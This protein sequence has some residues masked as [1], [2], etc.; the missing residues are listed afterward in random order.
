MEFEPIVDFHKCVRS[1]SLPSLHVT[2][3]EG[4]SR[5]STSA[6][7]EDPDVS[8]SS[9]YLGPEDD[10]PVPL[11][12]DAPYL[13][14]TPSFSR[15][16]PNA[17][18][19]PSISGLRMMDPGALTLGGPRWLVQ[20]ASRKLSISGLRRMDPSLTLTGPRCLVQPGHLPRHSI[21]GQRM[22]L[23]SFTLGGNP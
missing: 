10:P 22:T 5:A 16:C 1:S 6:G 15:S 12:A 2:P 23:Q 9:I 13:C 3:F 8:M 18:Q 19:Q 11:S 20:P 7:S 17:S 4:G 21:W 14:M